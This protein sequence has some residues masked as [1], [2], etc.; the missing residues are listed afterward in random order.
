VKEGDLDDFEMKNDSSTTMTFS[1]DK[2]T[3]DSYNNILED[4]PYRTAQP[5]VSLPQIHIYKKETSDISSS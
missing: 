5:K 1:Y 3:Q 2:K 4:K